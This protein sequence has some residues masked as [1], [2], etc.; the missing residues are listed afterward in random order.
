MLKNYLLIALRNIFRQ[1]SYSLINISGLAI[2]IMSCLLILMYVSDELSYDRFHERGDR[3]YRL[4]FSYTSP[5]GETF[6]HAVGPYR[7]ADE[8]ASRYPEID[9]AVRISF[10]SPM[11]LRN[12]EIEF[13]EDNIMF[14][15]SNIFKVFSFEIEGGDPSTTLTEPFTCVISDVVAH[16]FFGDENP[17]GNSL[18]V[19]TDQGEAEARITGV[20]QTLPDNS[21]IKPDVLVSMST[22]EYVFNDR[23]KFNWGEGTVA[24][25]LLLPENFDK[26]NLE[27]KF[28][29]L[30]TEIFDDA[31]ATKSIRYWLQPLFD[32]HL[33]SDLRFDFESHGNLTTV[34]V[35]SIVALFI[36]IIATINYMNLATARS[37][38]RA[39]EVALRKLVGGSRRQLIRQ[40][41]AE[42]ISLV[43]VAMIL[44]FILAELLLPF[45][46]TI[47]GKSFEASALL[48]W[49]VILAILLSSVLIGTMAGSY[50]SFVLASFRPIRVLYGDKRTGKGGFTMRKILVVLQ[51]SISIAL[52]IST[53]VVYSQ[54]N[55]LSKKDLGINPENVVLIPRPGNGYDTFKEEVLKNPRVLQ[56]TS[57]NK[58]PAGRLTSNLGY[59]A[60]G[61]P[62]D[63]EKSIKIVTVDFDFFETLENRIVEGRSF[64]KE[65][66]MDSVSTFILNQT[67]VKDIGWED[68]IG[69]WFETSTLDPETNNWKT[70]RGIVVGVAEDFHFES[71]HNTIQPV[72]FF[73]DNYWISWMSVKISDSG[74]PAT[75]DFLESEYLKADPGAPF[76][77]SFYM[78]EIASLY[79]EERQ[80]LRLFIVF[81]LLAIFIASLGI[82]GLASFSVEQR[83]RE[84]GIRKVAGS[85]ERRI[86]LLISN[87]FAIL[88]L[89][90]NLLAWPVT[91]YFMRNW[92][93]D[94]PYRIK[95]GI[96]LFLISALL[97]LFIAML[98]VFYQAWRAA[99]L[100]PA[101]ALRSE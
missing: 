9:E 101:E 56:V 11:P 74:I 80:F 97:A 72:C 91:W 30:I 2:G 28:P 19:D 13:V 6:N 76:E 45:F 21:H 31:E 92:L 3:I 71:V 25:Y 52:I 29:E 22:A 95:L 7:L 14:A 89:I 51:F 61:I 78:D 62:E 69:K 90:A 100:N 85:S 75:L 94:F 99:N 24:Y 70:R 96:H 18:Q 39:R 43:L 55:H 64:S 79:I 1:K 93:M 50:P 63:E 66:G 53:L 83:T 35:F 26:E 27:A 60:E 20:F 87:E 15:D 23:Q 40:F 81:A 57:S 38:R 49:K 88:V 8:L 48:N 16:K 59:T 34:Y 46:N 4:F 5:N 32:T 54:W 33:K 65:F 68:P 41:L 17:V 44:G 47:S 42:S 37:A 58:R 82:L 84:I 12:G 77:Y 10:T 67:A 98:T 36:L 73:V 86:I